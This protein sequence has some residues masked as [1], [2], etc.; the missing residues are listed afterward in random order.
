MSQPLTVGF[1]EIMIRLCPEGHLRLRQSLPGRLVTSCAGAE[2]NVCASIAILGGR[3]RYVTALPE[4]DL[5]TACLAQLRA[6]GVDT[7]QVRLT[8]NHRIGLFFVEKGA[9]QRPSRVVYDREG[10]SVALTAAE[11]YDWDRALDGASW[12]HLSG[13]TPGL[14]A[15]AAEACVRAAEIARGKGLKVSCDLNFRGKLWRWVEGRSARDL[16]REV[17]PR[18]LA[19]AHLVIGNE[20]D[21]A[22]VLDLHAEG[23]D[24]RSGVLHIEG[25]RSVAAG[26]A[27][28]FPTVQQVAL[29]LRE[30][31]SADH[32]HWGALLYDV[33]SHLLHLHPLDPQGKYRPFAIQDI[34]DRVG[35]GD[36]FAGALIF[37]LQDPA[38]GEPRQALAFAVAASCLAHSIE[39][40]FNFHTRQEVMDLVGGFASGRVVR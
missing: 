35:G 20:E 7:N 37:A 17:M 4:G 25:Y 9:N 30:S 10:S 32:N 27:R 29:T 23:S 2:A 38:L 15:Q 11:A 26:I 5:A 39:G 34:V 14:S 6:A 8:K 19:H 16:A 28:R 40:D 3:S 36:A 21:A 1:G 22:D 13:I 12:L 18:I 31:I 33:P 24:T